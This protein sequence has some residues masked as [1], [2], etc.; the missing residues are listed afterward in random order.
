[1]NSRVSG[2]FILLLCFIEIPVLN[3]AQA[4]D[5]GLFCLHFVVGEWWV[6]GGGG[7]GSGGGCGKE[8]SILKWVNSLSNLTLNM[9]KKNGKKS[10][11]EVLDKSNA[12][13]ASYN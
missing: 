5:L 1:M 10:K 12:E 13:K 8:G 2:S 11:V 6:R 4:S 3:S 9:N 7:G